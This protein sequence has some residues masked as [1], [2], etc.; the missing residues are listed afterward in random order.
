MSR[1]GGAASLTHGQCAPRSLP[2]HKDD[3]AEPDAEG[4]VAREQARGRNATSW[5]AGAPAQ[6]ALREK[7]DALDPFALHE[8]LEAWLK[9]ILAAP[10]KHPG[11]PMLKRQSPMPAARNPS[12][13]F[14][15]VGNGQGTKTE[16]HTSFFRPDFLGFL[17]LIHDP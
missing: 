6:R 17:P 10:A 8:E 7:F 12:A 2:R 5:R 15:H 3:S 16:R 13:S 4:E 11:S 9:L 1:E 14:F